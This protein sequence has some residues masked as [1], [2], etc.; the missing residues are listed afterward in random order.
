MSSTVKQ[1]RRFR[2]L[3]APVFLYALLLPVLSIDVVARLLANARTQETGTLVL[4]VFYESTRALVILLD[5]G[6]VA[7]LVFGRAAQREARVLAWFLLF[8]GVAYAIAFGGGGYVGPFQ[9]WLTRTLL[10][11][12]VGRGVLSV[13]FGYPDWSEWLALAALVRFS[14]LFPQPINEAVIEG[15]GA[16]DRAGL[17]RSVPG[18]GLDVG[19]SARKL[20][21]RA[22]GRGWLQDGPL[23]TFCALGALLSIVLRG[24]A[25]KPLLWI[26]FF[27]LLAVAIT[28]FRASYVAGDPDARRRIRWLARCS[29]A[30]LVLFVFSGIVGLGESTASE[31]GVFVLL[32]LA[33]V[34]VLLGFGAALLMRGPS[35]PAP[36]GVRVS[37]D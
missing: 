19:S 32:T 11:R 30:G 20:V 15:S 5:L 22:K 24:S 18:A 17:M 26:P 28:A 10:A 1:V 4:L 31:I 7:C 8:G 29:L 35:E 21:V 34:A 3:I 9:E 37:A 12:G 2:L 27:L 14:L 6:V 33:P 36:T 23:W 16:Q 25:L 13:L